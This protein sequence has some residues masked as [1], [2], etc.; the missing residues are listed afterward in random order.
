MAAVQQA[1]PDAGCLTL[2]YT[3]CCLLAPL[4]CVQVWVVVLSNLIAILLQTLAAR[5]GLVTGKHLAQVR[6]RGGH[7]G[8]AAA[9]AGQGSSWLPTSTAHVHCSFEGK[10]QQWRQQQ[11][12]NES[13][14]RHPVLG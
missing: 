2:K 8:P 3:P 6:G 5:L 1:S 11:Q 9:G 13:R 7:S 4:V 14:S 12:A 10:Q